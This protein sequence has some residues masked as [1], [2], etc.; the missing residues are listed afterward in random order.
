[1]KYCVT[2]RRLAALAVFAFCNPVFAADQ[3][4]GYMSGNELFKFC[5][6]GPSNLSG[7]QVDLGKQFA[8]LYVQGIHD[9]MALYSN[10]TRQNP[11]WCLSRRVD[12]DQLTDVVCLYMRNNPQIRHT[13]ASGSV[14]AA[15]NEAF[16]CRK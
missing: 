13:G 3:Q 12:V 10:T 16:P 1:M 6:N 7:I 8:G 15:L 14:V 2:T 11:L 9:Y 5:T 4:P